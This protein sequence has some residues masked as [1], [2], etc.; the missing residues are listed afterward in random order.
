ML[1]QL[2]VAIVVSGY[3]STFMKYVTYVAVCALMDVACLCIMYFALKFFMIVVDCS[4]LYE[5]FLWDE[6][7][8]SYLGPIRK[9]DSVT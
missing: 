3:G 1:L 5:C 4:V 9:R 2:L 8:H 6:C 7:F